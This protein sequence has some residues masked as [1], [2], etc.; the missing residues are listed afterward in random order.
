MKVRIKVIRLLV[1]MIIAVSSILALFMYF[2]I[3]EMRLRGADINAELDRNAEQSVRHELQDLADNISNY[4]L[5]LE[6]EIDRSMLNA[7]RV[8]YEEDRLSEGNLT[9]SDL[10]RIRDETGMSDMYLGDAD[11]V[12]TISTEPEAIGL[13]LFDIW[14]GYRMLVTGEADYLPSDLKVKAETGEIFKFTAI[15]RA[16]GR[17][18]LE[19]AL[20]A[21]AIEEY[22]QR[23][24]DNNRSIRSMNLFDSDLM[25]LTNNQAEGV[26]PGFTRG[27]TVPRGTTEIDNFFIG[28]TDIVI[29]MDRQEA[30]IYYPVVD[31]DRVRYVLYIDIDTTRYFSMQNLV[32]GSIAELVR[33]ST[34]LSGLSLGTVLAALLVFT[35]VI[36]FMT[37]KFIMRLEEAMEAAKTASQ[38]KSNFLSNMSHEM[39]TPMNAIIG[40][41]AIGKKTENPEEKDYALNKIGDASSHLLGVI[42]D[43]LDMAKIEANKLELSP[44]EYNFENMLQ[45]VLMLFNYRVDEKE[46]TLIVNIDKNIPIYVVGDDQRLAQIVTNL[47]ANALKFTPNGGEIKLEA[48]VFSETDEYCELLI[49]VSD[50]GIGVTKEKQVKLFDAFEQAESGTSREYGG[51]G[52]GLPITKRIVELMDGSIRVESEPGKGSKFTV[53][54]KVLRGEKS[55]GGEGRDPEESCEGES[56][57]DENCESENCGGTTGE[58]AGKRVLLAEDIEINR[59]ILKT[60]LEDTGLEIDCAENGKEALEAIEAAPDRYDL[61]FM[62]LQMPKMDGLEAT[63]LIRALPALR[64]YKLPIIA[65]TANVFKDDIEEC[66]AAGMDDHLGKPLDINKVLEKLRIFLK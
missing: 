59:E 53:R 38:S 6:A 31:G 16:E 56:C 48:A 7:A 3:N 13:S 46:Q 36:L 14:D 29:V 1:I 26:T 64:E 21:S 25:T 30:Q 15:P 35:V 27:S 54:V 57:T 20:N 47:L 9:L 10:K 34:F 63:R 40:M 66:F 52:L 61:V 42:S 11:G 28:Y 43:V 32:E 58:F 45:K 12:F 24:V 5:V 41:T 51:T 23:L 4:I 17:G 22:L 33:E 44:I 19:S 49:E 60:L 50:N 2:T 18:I 8:L 65:L 55:L 62:D 39:R 37:N